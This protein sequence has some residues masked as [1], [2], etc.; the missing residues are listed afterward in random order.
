MLD[1]THT[2]SHAAV[3]RTAVL[4][5]TVSPAVHGLPAAVH[6]ILVP[7]YLTLHNVL[8]TLSYVCGDG[9]ARMSRG[10][11]SLARVS[12]ALGVKYF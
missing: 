9:I 2:R 11:Y 7:L 3:L 4:K 6:R 10:M 12:I 1:S 8:Q 5:M